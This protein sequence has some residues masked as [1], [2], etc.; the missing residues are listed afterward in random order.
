MEHTRGRGGQAEVWLGEELLTVCDG[1]SASGSITPPGLVE[2]VRF[3]YMTESPV[4]LT[5]TLDQNPRMRKGLDPVGGWAYVGYGQVVSLMPV[6]ID[7]GA[8]KME[9]PTWATDESLIGQ[10]VKVAIDRLEIER[11][12]EEDSP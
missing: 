3:R 11:A 4:A 2:G 7:F 1:V 10:Y 12:D 9:D 5:T 8:L 6:V